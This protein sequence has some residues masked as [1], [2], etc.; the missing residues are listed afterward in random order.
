MHLP[1]EPE[2]LGAGSVLWVILPPVGMLYMLYMPL[3]GQ[4]QV[5]GSVC[6]NAQKASRELGLQQLRKQIAERSGAFPKRVLCP[7]QSAQPSPLSLKQP[8]L[9]QLTGSAGSQVLSP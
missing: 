8:S 9:V 5:S 6:V 1:E 4:T 3:W 7:K 2:M